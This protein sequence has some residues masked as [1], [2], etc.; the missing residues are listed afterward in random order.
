MSH[1]QDGWIHD[2]RA[3]IKDSPVDFFE[4]QPHKYWWDLALCTFMAYL[5]AGLYLAFPLFS[6]QQF[7]CF[8]FAVFWLYRGNSMVH[9]V[10]HLGK[11]Q[12]PGFA[13][14][15]NMLLGIPTLFPSTFFTSHHRD[16]HSGRHY[17]T[18]QD[19]EYIVNVFTPGSIASTLFYFVHVT[20]YPIFVLFRFLLAPISFLRKDWREFTLRRLSSFTLNWK[21]ERNL[22]RL[23]RKT[24]VLV[25]LLCCARAWL[26]P[27][28]VLLGVTTWVRIPLMYT[29]AIT[30]L[31]ANQMRFFADHHFE[32]QG[33]KMSMAD[34]IT[35]SCNYSKN[36]FLT[37][38][39]FPFTIRFHALH[40]MFPTI[41]YH[42]LPAA[43]RHLTE[44]LP[45]DSVYHTLDQPSWW[46]TA[47]QTLRF[48]RSKVPV[49]QV[50]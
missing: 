26:I 37:W 35:D 32:S 39:F 16:H 17:G 18:P 11:K 3:A 10:S 20:V 46:H 12:F 30:I 21:Y 40:H 25:E 4:V 38:L 42:N 23:D 24:F 44:K 31:F 50:R 15:W 28:S 19:P 2:A 1:V 14:G 5:C 49:R 22:S 7:V 48:S 8:P 45:V 43:H 9:E 34:H 13:F 47:K 41:P 6:W 29:L 27:I 33:E 36:D